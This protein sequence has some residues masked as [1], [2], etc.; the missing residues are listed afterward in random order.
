MANETKQPTPQTVHNVGRENKAAKL[1]RDGKFPVYLLDD[2]RFA[3]YWGSKW[4][5]KPSLKAIDGVIGKGRK[6]VRV[7]QCSEPNTYYFVGP[8]VLEIAALTSDRKYID[9]D[10][11]QRYRS[12]GN[13][14]RYDEALIA[15]LNDLEKRR[16][17]VEKELR[18]EHARILRKAKRVT[19][20]TLIAE[21]KD[22]AGLTCP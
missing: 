12:Y 2:G 22:D 1:F 15:A 7:F 3:V 10:G 9:K 13:M 20:E 18:A 14:Y 5:I 6:S 19:T 17:K 16:A 11:K 4:V 8:E 21:L